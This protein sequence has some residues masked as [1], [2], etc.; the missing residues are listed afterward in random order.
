MQIN[1]LTR[2]IPVYFI[3]WHL[4]VLLHSISLANQELIFKSKWIVYH[5]PDS[6]FVGKE[7]LDSRLWILRIWRVAIVQRFAGL[8]RTWQHSLWLIISVKTQNTEP[9]NTAFSLEKGSS[10]SLKFEVSENSRPK[11]DAWQF[12]FWLLR[13]SICPVFL[14]NWPSSHGPDFVRDVHRQVPR[15]GWSN[16]IYR[17]NYDDQF[18]CIINSPDAYYS[19]PNYSIQL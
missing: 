16:N 1:F 6:N 19:I 10:L 14:R 12:L 7:E 11:F 18:S 15:K 17:P 9:Q 4:S 2:K 3:L 8:F 5:A 13:E